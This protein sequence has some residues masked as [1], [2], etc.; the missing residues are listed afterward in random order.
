M[1]SEVSHRIPHTRAAA[2]DSDAADHGEGVGGRSGSA[3]RNVDTSRRAGASSAAATGTPSRV[4]AAATPAKALILSPET[5][6]RQQAALQRSREC[7]GADWGRWLMAVPPSPPPPSIA[8]ISHLVAVNNSVV[9]EIDED[10]EQ[11]FLRVRRVTST[12]KEVLV[13]IS[14]ED[15]RSGK[16]DLE[17]R[18]SREVDASVAYHRERYAH[19]DYVDLIL[20]DWVD[21]LW[22]EAVHLRE[23][24]RD[25]PDDYPSAKRMHSTRLEKLRARQPAKVVRIKQ[26]VSMRRAKSKKGTVTSATGGEKGPTKRRFTHNEDQLLIT[27]LDDI[28]NLPAE[29]TAAGESH[30]ML[31]GYTEGGGEGLWWWS[32]LSTPSPPSP[33][34]GVYNIAQFNGWDSLVGTGDSATLCGFSVALRSTVDLK[35]RVRLAPLH[36]MAPLSSAPPLPPLPRCHCSSAPSLATTPRTSPPVCGPRHCPIWRDSATPSAPSWR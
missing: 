21:R 11:A 20:D 16:E 18:A 25:S 1:D 6:R 35:D 32:T 29:H 12:R 34:A 23:V 24:A 9:V 5:L 28:M 30:A 19:S 33:R 13:P 10:K 8:C 36:T 14:L 17:K 15:A 26:L 22:E 3:A 7:R 27:L 4:A 31:R 2:A